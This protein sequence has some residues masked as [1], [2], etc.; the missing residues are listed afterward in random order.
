MIHMPREA[1]GMYGCHADV[2]TTI[3]VAIYRLCISTRRC[4]SMVHQPIDLDDGMLCL[5][6]EM[7]MIQVA[8]AG[9][10]R[11]CRAAA[12]LHLM[13][14]VLLDETERTNDTL[15]DAATATTAH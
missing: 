5:R 9:L 3:L 7:P 1:F 8:L 10:V 15:F 12:R 6:G 2:T 4:L 11:A 14:P 13:R